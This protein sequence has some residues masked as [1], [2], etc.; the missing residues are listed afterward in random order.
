MVTMLL[1][2]PE[3]LYQSLAR[4][5]SVGLTA[6]QTAAEFALCIPLAQSLFG[7]KRLQWLFNSVAWFL[8]C[9]FLIYIVSPFIIKILK[10]IKTKAVLYSALVLDVAAIVF[11][12]FAFGKLE[13]ATLFDEL[14]YALPYNRIFLR[15]F[16]DAPL[17]FKG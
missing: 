2:V 9:L 4:G 14:V 10:R 8:S 5:N 16:R 1:M 7:V 15:D 3:A 11:T 12:A 13:E 17:P 6:V